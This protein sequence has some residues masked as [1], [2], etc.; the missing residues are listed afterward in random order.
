MDAS[1]YRSG[2]MPVTLTIKQVPDDLADHLRQRAAAARRSLQGEL[3][4]ILEQAREGA[5]RPIPIVSSVREPAS[6]AYVVTPSKPVSRMSIP[7][8]R[9][10]SGK[11]VSSGKLSLDEL[12]Q[13][14]RKL[15]ASMPSESVDL[16]RRDRDAR[17]HR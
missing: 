6:P 15:G 12:W 16:I 5:S 13:R 1:S 4:L 3:L 14:A 7:K 2:D 10:P 11:K 17:H 8:S 9:P